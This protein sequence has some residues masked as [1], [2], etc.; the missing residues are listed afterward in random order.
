[1]FGDGTGDFG[2]VE[3]LMPVPGFRFD[4][5]LTATGAAD[6]REI[7]LDVIHFGDRYQWTAL[8]DMTGL[9]TARLAGRAT[10][11]AQA[12]AL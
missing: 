11:A 2:K 9:G 1:M 5:D 12:L 3:N 4:D 7:P 6:I 8:P 10:G